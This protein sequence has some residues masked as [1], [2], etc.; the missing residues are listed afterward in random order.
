[1]ENALLL[2][3][4]YEPINIVSWKKALNLL[5][6]GKVEVLA[7]YDREIRS[8]SFT[9]RLPSVLRLLKL[10][11]VRRG[12]QRV[13]FSRANIYARDR[14]T[15]QYCGT[16]C[17]AEDLTFDHVMPIVM[18][19]AKTWENIV[20]C[21]VSCNHRKGG[22][23]PEKAGMK[24]IRQPREPEW[25]PSMLHIRIGFRTAPQA[26]RDFLYWNVELEKG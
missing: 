19:G 2:N 22:R 6:R 21:C 7:E 17:R 16:A 3:A 26:W 18:G 9:V 8:I 10:A 12:F 24:L 23:T 11:R 14:H 5:C 1:M 4:S 15:C 25:V 20:T 13:K